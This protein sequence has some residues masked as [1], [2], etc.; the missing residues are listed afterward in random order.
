RVACGGSNLNQKGCNASGEAFGVQSLRH[1]LAPVSKRAQDIRAT[2]A[3]EATH[4]SCAEPSDLLRRRNTRGF[5]KK[6][7]FSNAVR[8]RHGRTFQLEGLSQT[9]PRFTACQ[10]VHRHG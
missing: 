2:D 10:G 6:R 7:T 4:S 9:Q 8:G 1:Q 5:C 3:A